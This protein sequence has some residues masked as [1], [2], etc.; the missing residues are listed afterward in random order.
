MVYL[1]DRFIIFFDK[2]QTKSLVKL[3]IYDK[4]S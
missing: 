1:L 4:M 3:L 2:K